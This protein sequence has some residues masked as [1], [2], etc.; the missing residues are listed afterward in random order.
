MNDYTFTWL[1]RACLIIS[2][3][4]HFRCTFFYILNV[5]ILVL[6]SLSY[7]SVIASSSCRRNCLSYVVACFVLGILFVHFLQREWC[8]LEIQIAIL[9]WFP[10][11]STSVPS[12]LR[13][14]ITFCASFSV[15]YSQSALVMRIQFPLPHSAQSWGSISLEASFFTHRVGLLAHFHRLPWICRCYAPLMVCAMLSGVL[16]LS[17]REPSSHICCA[18]IFLGQL[19]ALNRHENAGFWDL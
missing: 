4:Y 11:M 12:R 13:F 14:W 1:F 10:L 3:F 5:N 9:E 8:F 15:C 18:C 19:L 16:L 2:S 7:C 6:N 17:H